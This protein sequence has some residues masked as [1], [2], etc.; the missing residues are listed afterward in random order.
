MRSVSSSSCGLCPPEAAFPRSV[1]HSPDEPG[2]RAEVR[3]RSKQ[4]LFLLGLV[5]FVYVLKRTGW[6]IVTE[7][8]RRL[9]WYLL[10]IFALSGLK[11]VISAFAWAAAFLPEER[12]S[13]RR[14]FGARV[15]GEALNYLSIAGPLL[16]EPVKASLLR[17][18]RFVPGLASTLL[19]TTVNAMAATLVAVAGLVLLVLSRAPGQLTRY[20]SAAAIVILSVLVFGF[21]YL[22]KRRAPFLTASYHR[23]CRIP[24]LSSGQLGEKLSMIEQRM[25]QLSFERPGR[26]VAIFLLSFAA[27]VLALLE[28]YVVLL[29]LGVS[30]SFAGILV[31]EG[32]T[33]IAKAVFF[34]VPT[35]IGVDEG[36]SAGIFALLTLSPSGGV[37]LALARRLRALF[38][39]AAGLAF[40]F[41][42][43]QESTHHHSQ[44]KSRA[45]GR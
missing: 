12:Q 16:G 24:K 23:L 14:L 32:F 34:F 30:L 26:F 18:V 19:E 17:G 7:G 20:A 40:L 22:L 9:G 10:V 43:S 8:F 29:S 44:A 25:H 11:Y 3:H 31:I 35:R 38:W 37:L 39:S 5:F 41:A 28:I 13:W 45:V 1:P 42:H 4:F 27:Q 6:S 15:A 36:S 33:K 2:I 21:L